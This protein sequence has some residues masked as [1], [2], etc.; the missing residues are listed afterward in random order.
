MLRPY[1]F[2][3]SFNLA[4]A[5]GYQ[6]KSIHEWALCVLVIFVELGPPYC[7]VPFILMIR[8]IE[9]FKIISLAFF[10]INQYA[11]NKNKFYPMKLLDLMVLI[12]YTFVVYQMNVNRIILAY[13]LIS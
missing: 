4:R 10:C 3:Y 6:P 7:T 9:C 1:S 8:T 5:L 2:L 13:G 12:S 11:H